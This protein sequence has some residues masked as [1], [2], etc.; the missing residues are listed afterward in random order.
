MRRRIVERSRCCYAVQAEAVP[1]GSDFAM[2]RSFRCAVAARRF[3][4]IVAMLVLL[5]WW[6]AGIGL[7]APLQGV[8]A[9]AAARKAGSTCSRRPRSMRLRVTA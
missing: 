4:G 7:L 6:L 2:I 9:G 1:R 5:A 8:P 3:E